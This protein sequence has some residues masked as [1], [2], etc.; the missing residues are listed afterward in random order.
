MSKIMLTCLSAVGALA[1][2]GQASAQGSSAGA[3]ARQ[4]ARM[5]SCSPAWNRATAYSAGGAASRDGVNYTAAY[6]TQGNI[7]SAGASA[8]GG[9][10][11]IAGASCRPAAKT[12]AKTSDHDAN[13]SPATLQFLKTNTGLDGEQWDN[14]MKL[15]NKPE[16]DSL[17][18]T[19]FYGYCEDIGD[20][21]GFTIGIFGATTGGPNDGGPDGPALFKE[22]DA[23]SGAANPSII[24]GLNRA[25]AHGSMQGAILKISDDKKTFC[26]KIGALQ[27][28]AA[29]RE[30]MWHTFYNVYIKF[31]IQQARQRGF[32]TALTIG[33]FVD[34]ALNQGASGDSGTLAGVLSRSGS[35]SDE[36]TFMTS[37]YAQ[38]SKIVDTNDYNQPP[39]GKNRVKQ[40]STLLGMGETDLKNA[41]AA[42]LKVTDWQLK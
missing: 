23:A 15:I 17:D 12:A 35:S 19:K 25:G 21:R 2:A 22:F 14:I 30:A 8:N 37:F 11:W 42:V 13:F 38:R 5:E 31:S 9:Q 16:Q 33:S 20:R 18:W 41:D 27:S 3:P 10:P 6:W 40:W 7:P 34:T 28:N 32:S 29:W 1:L 4:A 36:K 26:G 24:G 39:N